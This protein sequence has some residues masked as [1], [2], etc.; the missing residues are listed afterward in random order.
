MEHEKKIAYFY[1]KSIQAT[2][3]STAS[4]HRRRRNHPGGHQR[5]DLHAELAHGVTLSH[6][7]A[8]SYT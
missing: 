4:D 7:H 8:P 5:V 2:F 6:P 1:E 3:G